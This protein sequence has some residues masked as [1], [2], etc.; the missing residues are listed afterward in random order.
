MKTRVSVPTHHYEVP[1]CDL[2]GQSGPHPRAAGDPGLGLAEEE[3]VERAV[4]RVLQHEGRGDA[5]RG[6]PG[7]DG[8]D[9]TH[10]P[11][12]HGGSYNTVSVGP[13]LM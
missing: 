13:V 10:L 7:I 4:G 9:P 12:S 1:L 8:E 6:T 3:G 2:I 5:W 11:Y